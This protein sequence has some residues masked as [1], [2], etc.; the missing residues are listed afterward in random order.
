MWGIDRWPQLQ[1]KYVTRLLNVTPKV[2][3]LFGEMLPRGPVKLGFV[4]TLAVRCR[5]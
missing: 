2:P 4:Q 5:S 1:V 3:P